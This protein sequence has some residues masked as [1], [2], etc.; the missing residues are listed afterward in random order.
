MTM[1]EKSI[2]EASKGGTVIVPPSAQ[3]AESGQVYFIKTTKG[4]FPFSYLQKEQKLT[5]KQEK[6]RRS[7]QKEQTT[8]LRGHGL[9]QHPLN[10]SGLLYLQ[11]NS[12]YFDACVRQIAID[13]VGQGWEVKAKE[14]KKQ[15]KKLKQEIEDFLIDPNDTDEDITDIIKKAVIDWGTV[16]WWALEVKRD[17]PPDGRVIGLWHIPAHTIWR[18]KDK[19]R[20]VQIRNDK[21]VWF[22]KFNEGLTIS[23]ETGEKTNNKDKMAHEIIFQV[24]YYQKSD[25][26]GRPNILPAVSAAV[27]LMGARDYNL[28]FF[29]NYGVPTAMIV[30]EGR[31]NAAAAK[32][33][34][35]FLDVEVKGSAN[36]HKTIVLKPPAEG[37]VTYIPMMKEVKEAS[38]KNYYKTMRDEILAAYKMPPYRIGIAEQGPVSKDTEVLTKDGWKPIPKIKIG[39]TVATL[40]LVTDRVEFQEVEQL[41]K[42]YFDRMVNFRNKDGTLDILVSHNHRMWMRLSRSGSRSSKYKWYLADDLLDQKRRSPAKQWSVRVA[43]IYEGKP[44]NKISPDLAALIGWI[45]SEGSLRYRKGEGYDLT[46]Y[47]KPGEKS[48]EIEFLLNRL[49]VRYTRKLMK[50]KKTGFYP[51]GAPRKNSEVY[52]YYILSPDKNKIGDLMDW[53][54]RIPKE[55]FESSLE[56]KLRCIDALVKGDGHQ[57][58]VTRYYYSADEVLANQVATLA[59]LSG[60]NTRIKKVE[61]WAYSPR[62]GRRLSTCFEVVIY[63]S[64]IQASRTVREIKE[65]DYNDYGYCLTVKNGTLIYRRKGQPFIA[66]NSLGGSTAAEHTKIYASSI[67]QPL[68]NKTAKIIT[69]LIQKGLGQD[70]YYFEWGKLDTRDMDAYVKRLQLEFMM[71]AVS[72]NDVR[73]LL[74]MEPRQDPLGDQYYVAANYVPVGEESVEKRE[75]LAVSTLENLAAKVEEALAEGRAPEVLK[76]NREPED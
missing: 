43:A 29:E 39:D 46:I 18:H 30:L 51:N 15:D 68:K 60:L 31:W 73:R 16:G 49:G 75:Q 27:G 12:I 21:R 45:A 17:D 28:A 1:K 24:E 54:K 36:A 23:A 70:I 76:Q 56:A 11:E 5:K 19:V 32:Q 7:K 20:F 48:E 3:E 10:V 71:G 9:V 41:H 35:N 53:K 58:G 74:G 26:Y 8:W 33:I 22:A 6:E 59:M 37:K 67:I 25:Y 72:P 13:V 66:G 65:V 38:F 4:I 63:Q 50:V 61:R 57:S 44:G 40:N 2:S 14:G 55:I 69:K 47:Q 64:Q 42:A 62:T 52:C 34:V